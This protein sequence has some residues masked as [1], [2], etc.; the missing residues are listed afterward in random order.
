MQRKI[1]YSFILTAFLV[2]LTACGSD[3]KPDAGDLPPS[4]SGITLSIAC[5]ENEQQE[6][7]YV[8]HC[9]VHSVDGNSNP[10]SGLTFD[11]SLVINEKEFHRETGNIFSTEPIAFSDHTVDFTRTDVKKT[12]NLIILPTEETTDPSYLGNWEIAAV[13]ND[14]TLV[15]N[16]FNLESAEDLTYVIGN[17][18][19]YAFGNSATAHIEYPEE[20]TTS[21]GEEETGLEGF[22]YFDIVYDPKLRGETIFLGAHTYG[23]RIGT[24]AV[25]RLELEDGE[26][27]DDSE[28][29]E[30]VDDG[31]SGDGSTGTPGE[32]EEG[33]FWCSIDEKCMP[34]GDTTSSCS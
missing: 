22:F 1:I 7:A 31:N 29:S 17:E 33:Y 27:E 16:A 21:E 34:A 32:C 14:L 11:V 30:E 3:S 12:D 19:R 8:A 18:T 25:L 4:E 24:A 5:F 26:N 2:L 20:T 15:E 13:N 23:N 10:V 6:D 28:E 9:Y